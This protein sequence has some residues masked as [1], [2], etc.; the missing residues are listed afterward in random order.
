MPPNLWYFCY[1]GLRQVSSLPWGGL[2]ATIFL[3]L[4]F[5]IV[6]AKGGSFNLPLLFFYINSI[7]LVTFLNKILEIRSKYM[8]F[9]NAHDFI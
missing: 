3:M 2:L 4:E 8:T 5:Y 9:F 7:I 1:S 6:S